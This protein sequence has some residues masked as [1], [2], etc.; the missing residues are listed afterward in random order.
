[1]I[2]LLPGG[3]VVAVAAVGALH[4]AVAGEEVAAHTQRV[5][6]GLVLADELAR[7][8]RRHGNDEGRDGRVRTETR[9]RDDIQIRDEIRV[10]LVTI[11]QAAGHVRP[12]ADSGKFSE[13]FFLLNYN[14]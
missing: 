8:N 2:D 14:C 1:M 5:A 6:V 3:V 11:V 4:P 10:E 9:V 12:V 7:L 13:K